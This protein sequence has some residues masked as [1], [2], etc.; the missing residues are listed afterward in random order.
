MT[1]PYD[2]LNLFNLRN[3][4]DVDETKV[5]TNDLTEGGDHFRL[6]YILGVSFGS[7]IF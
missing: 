3:K 7:C 1:N 4:P 2:F 6:I 5:W